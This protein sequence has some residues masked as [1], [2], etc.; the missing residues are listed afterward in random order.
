M[1]RISILIKFVGPVLCLGL[2]TGSPLA[3]TIFIPMSGEDVTTITDPGV[4]W[5]DDEGITHMRGVMYTAVT[6]GQ[7]IDG[8]PINSVGYYEANINLDMETG[9][10]DLTAW[11][12]N[13]GT[14]GDIAG[15]FRVRFAATLTGFLA[16]GTFIGPRGYDGFEGWKMR[17]TWTGIF[18]VPPNYYEGEYQIPGG[19]KSPGDEATTLSSVKALFR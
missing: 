8:I 3:Q 17:G 13:V 1:K 11:G 10:G 6:T 15:S 2:M 18:G 16:D 12:S 9:D 5:I 7:D 4:Q 19:D 14:Y